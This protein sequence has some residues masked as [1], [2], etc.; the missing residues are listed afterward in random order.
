MKDIS[1][2]QSIGLLK[3]GSQVDKQLKHKII[4]QYHSKMITYI[5]KKT[6]IDKDETDSMGKKT[7]EKKTNCVHI[8]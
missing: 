8:Q 6:Y 1:I 7:N 3:N 5:Q 2:N 4:I